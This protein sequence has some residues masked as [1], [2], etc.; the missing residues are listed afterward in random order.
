MVVARHPDLTTSI[1]SVN[2][3]VLPG[4]STVNSAAWRSC[5]WINHSHFQ[6]RNM[7]AFAMQH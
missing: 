4:R 2:F 7:S 5:S 1:P 6:H 3:K